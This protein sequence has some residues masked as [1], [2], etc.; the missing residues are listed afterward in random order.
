[1]TQLLISMTLWI[2]IT[3]I[4]LEDPEQAQKIVKTWDERHNMEI[5][6]DS[7]VDDQVSHK[8]S[9]QHHE[10]ESLTWKCLNR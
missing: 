7:G 5:F 3:G 6:C 9:R 4:N 10:S 1:L 2:S 8:A